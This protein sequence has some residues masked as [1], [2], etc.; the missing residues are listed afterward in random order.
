MSNHSIYIGLLFVFLCCQVTTSAQNQLETKTFRGIVREDQTGE[1]IPYATIVVDGKDYREKQWVLSGDDGTFRLLLPLSDSLKLSVSCVGFVTRTWDETSTNSL[2]AYYEIRLEEDAKTLEGLEVIGRK[3]LIKLSDKGFSYD[4]DKDESVKSQSLL[5]AIRRVPLVSV[6]G[7]GK[8]TVRGSGDFS[9]FL[10]GK[11]FKMADM[12][13]SQV[14]EGLPASDIEKVEVITNPDASYGSDVGS[15]VINIITKNKKNSGYSLQLSTRTTTRPK[16]IS[17]AAFS[18]MTEKV[19]LSTQYIF[20]LD[21][22][23]KQPIHQ[24]RLIDNLGGDSSSLVS[25][26]I[27]SGRSLNHT[28]HIML[29]WSIDSLNTI[30]ADAHLRYSSFNYLT[31]WMKKYSY[32]NELK[33]YNQ[34]ITSRYSQTATEANVIYR[35]L[36]KADKTE[37]FSL[38]YRYAYSPDNR[39]ME[40]LNE[41]L[42]E[43]G[44]KSLSKGGVSEHTLSADVTI[45]KTNK[46]FAKVG[47]LGVYRLSDARIQYFL[48][49]K[50]KEW[51]MG[52][53]DEYRQKHLHAGAY[54][55]SSY[56]FGRSVLTG[57]IRAEYTSSESRRALSNEIEKGS[58]ANFYPNLSLSS[59]VTDNTQLSFAY[60]YSIKRPS[61]WLLNPYRL[62]SDE[63]NTQFGNPDLKP[64][65]THSFAPS[66]MNF[67]EKYFVYLSM[68]YKYAVNPIYT[69]LFANP[70]NPQTLFSTYDNA[71][72]T[73]NVELMGSVN[74][75]PT[76]N[77]SVNFNVWT[78][79]LWMRKDEDKVQKQGYFNAVGSV[80]WTLP[81]DWASG[82]NLSYTQTSPSFG[83][84]FKHTFYYSLYLS[85]S[86]LD[87][88]LTF[89]LQT[90]DPFR[91][92]S[93]FRATEWGDNFRQTRSNAIESEG[94]SLKV[95]YNLSS[96]KKP[97]I[98]RNRSLSNSDMDRNTGVN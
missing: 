80:D 44:T 45:I 31:D 2:K 63:Y 62:S 36:R 5:S 70:D 25:E 56:T 23:S 14:L 79:Y 81:K 53:T 29:D 66:V 64:E 15:T 58:Y 91:P 43:A 47:T 34:S 35:N 50:E 72:S 65:Y 86:F 27:S 59:N 33:D 37:R 42:P 98:K 95:M 73:H 60:N 12:N 69:W 16:H 92:Y 54:V 38:G 87:N 32:R 51:I 18:F 41:N 9:I 24:E 75:R 20:D 57:G 96:G 90:R 84:T 68:G 21:D 48:P 77:L 6:D 8:L 82:V 89:T 17:S 61:I 10:N 40:T 13:P 46:W 1:P 26:G 71:Q 97:Q 3:R 52:E 83:Q 76:P 22:Y 85:K 67:G 88:S 7:T 4:F 19:R 78:G 28:G 30:Y 93:Y 74:Y 49:V 39:S 11:P 94:V 55:T